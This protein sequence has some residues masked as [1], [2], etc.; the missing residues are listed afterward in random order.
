[1]QT[2][3]KRQNN[4]AEVGP[5]ES[6]VVCQITIAL[7]KDTCFCDTYHQQQMSISNKASYSECKI[8]PL[9]VS[10]GFH[11]MKLCQRGIAMALRLHVCPSQ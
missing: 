4:V 10:F 7:R 11:C 5:S 8:P 1:M 3:T 9:R 2:T 6:A